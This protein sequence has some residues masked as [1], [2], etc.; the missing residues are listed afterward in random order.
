MVRK[1]MRLRKNGEKDFYINLENISN[2]LYNIR[3]ID[4]DGNHFNKKIIKY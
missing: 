3:I 2:G 1:F 4:L